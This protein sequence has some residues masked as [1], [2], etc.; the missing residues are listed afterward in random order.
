M[1][2]WQLREMEEDGLVCRSSQGGVFSDGDGKIPSACHRRDE[3][4][5][6]GILK[7]EPKIGMSSFCLTSR[8]MVCSSESK[9][10]DPGLS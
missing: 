4:R 2:A 9:M 10:T 7:E 1:L 8:R 3:G 5:G 6:T